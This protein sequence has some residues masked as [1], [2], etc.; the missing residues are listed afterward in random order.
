MIERGKLSSLQLGCIMYLT[1]IATSMMSAPSFSH[2]QAENDMWLS[3]IIG[4]IPAFALIGM[5]GTLHRLYPGKSLIEYSRSIMGNWMGT[6]LNVAFLLTCLLQS[7]NQIRQFGE[8]MNQFFFKRTPL[9]VVISTLFV[10]CILAVRLGVEV[11]GRA[12]LLFMPFVILIVVA[13][14]LPFYKDVQLDRVLPLFHDGMTPVLRSSFYIQIWL[15]MYVYASFFLPFLSDV[16]HAAKRCLQSLLATVVTLSSVML[17][18]LFILGPATSS[19]EYPFMVLARYL[20]MFDFLE[21]FDAVIMVFW[22]MNVFIRTIVT[23]YALSLGIAQLLKLSDYRPLAFPVGMLVIAIC[24]WG[25]PSIADLFAASPHMS[26]IFF[27]AYIVIPLLL[28]I[29]AMVRN[30]GSSN[31][32]HAEP[33][34]IS[35][36]QAGQQ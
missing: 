29:V 27:G 30:S 21:Q 14:F 13:F 16:K 10:V 34:N 1:V 32:E 9:A 22:V 23:L 18:I 15:P 2:S 17:L 28:Y 20:S 24:F 4:S 25:T 5:L 11:I 33:S 36:Q 3:P 8:L 12:S 19:Y 31:K 7:A 6:I 26:F 35:T